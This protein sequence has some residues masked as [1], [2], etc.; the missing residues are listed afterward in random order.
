MLSARVLAYDPE[1]IGRLDIRYRI[2][3]PVEV[4]QGKQWV[5]LETED[6]SFGG[7]FL[8]DPEPPPL[9][10]LLRLR[11]SL[12]FGLGQFDASAVVTRRNALGD[13]GRQLAG[14]GLAFYALG[15]ARREQWDLF[16][17]EAATSCPAVAETPFRAH[18]AQT[19]P[20]ASQRGA[21]VLEVTVGSLEDLFVLHS[22]D[23]SRAGI[24]LETE[25]EAYYAGEK[26][27]LHVVHPTSGSAFWIPCAVKRVV[28]N[29]S[30][31]I[32]VELSDYDPDRR[33]AFHDALARLID[34]EETARASK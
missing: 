32:A 18:R 19:E 9:R 27:S 30:R 4:R 21:P 24:F 12:P 25:P 26:I 29:R 5:R 13:P 10:Q 15:G 28:R 23:A 3:L 34:G 7:L 33:R 17:L 22:R 6:V 31:G 1:D 8:R 14:M 2:A 20:P 11:T 16:I